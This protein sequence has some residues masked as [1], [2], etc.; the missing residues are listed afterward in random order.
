MISLTDTFVWTGLLQMFKTQKILISLLT[1]GHAVR[2]D[3]QTLIKSFREI[4]ETVG[5]KSI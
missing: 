3:V 4:L 1:R 2:L 5:E